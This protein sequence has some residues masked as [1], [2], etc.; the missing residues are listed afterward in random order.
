[1]NAEIAAR[2]HG[3][4]PERGVLR[5]YAEQLPV[6]E[7][8][9][10][11]SLGEGDT[12]LVR[13]TT[14]ERDLGCAELY[15]KLESCN[16]TGILQGPRHGRRRRKG[17]R[18]RRDGAHV[19]LHRQH[20]RV[21]RR[22]RVRATASTCTSSCPTA[23]SRAASWRRASS[24]ARRSSPSTAT[25]MTA[26]RIARGD[27]VA[28]PD[29]AR[30]LREP[31][32]HRGPEDGGLRDLGR[33][34]RRAGRPGD[35]RRQRRQHHRVLA[36]LH[37]IPPHGAHEPPPTMLGFQ[38]A[39]AAPLVHGAPVRDPQT[40]A[41]AIRIG[42]PAS[43]RTAIEA[44]D[45]SGGSITAVTRRR[46]PRGI[47]AARAARKASSASRPRPPASPAC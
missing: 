18:G 21:G 24:T 30:E 40:V 1:M 13:S 9:P 17:D 47:R 22:L 46:D 3:D 2:I 20:Q 42:N 37:R 38:A 8:T 39:G 10:M 28:T 27:H 5:R 12:P 15:F 43:W 26:L 4:A 31:V 32:P 23:A 44:R 41:S 19:R 35:P 16:P 7:A 25:S 29:R 6:T 33:A 45:E 14:I 34:R 11:I 36:R